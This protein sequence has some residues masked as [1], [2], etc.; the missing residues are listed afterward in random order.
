MQR[1]EAGG[2]NDPVR[3]PAEVTSKLSYLTLEDNPSVISGKLDSEYPSLIPSQTPRPES[4][5]EC[6]PSGPSGLT[7]QTIQKKEPPA[8]LP[9]CTDSEACHF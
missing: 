7:V 8:R 3:P 5:N 1:G 2:E 9:C 6:S 4:S